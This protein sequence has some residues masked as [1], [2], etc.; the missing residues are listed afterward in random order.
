MA[1][2]LRQRRLSIVICTYDRERLLFETL[3]SIKKLGYL[4]VHDVI[5]VENTDEEFKRKGTIASCRARFPQIRIV[6]SEVAGLSRARNIGVAEAVSEIIAFL[7]DDAIPESGWAEGI[8]SCCRDDNV[9]YGGGPI[10][11]RWESRPPAWM[12]EEL[13]SAFTILDLGEHSR[14]L[15]QG[16]FVYGANMFF[17]ASALRSIGGFDESLGRVRNNL[18]GEEDLAVQK[19][20]AKIGSG[21]YA[22]NSRVKHFI[23]TNRANWPWLLK[24]FAWQGF[25]EISQTGRL[26]EYHREAMRVA[27]SNARLRQLFNDLTGEPLSKKDALER[28]GFIRA[29]LGALFHGRPEDLLIDLGPAAPLPLE[30]V[31]ENLVSRQCQNRS[32]TYRQSMVGKCTS[33]FFEFGRSH[34]Y[35]MNA[36]GDIGGSKLINPMF[37]PWDNQAATVKSLQQFQSILPEGTRPFFFTLDWVLHNDQ[38][39]AELSHLAGAGII[40]RIDQ[41]PTAIRNLKRVGQSTV[42]LAYSEKTAKWVEKVSGSECKVIRHPPILFKNVPAKTVRQARDAKL[43]SRTERAIS[44]ALMGEVRSG[45]GFELVIQELA[46][47]LRSETVNKIVLCLVGGASATKALELKQ[48]LDRSHLRFEF[49]IRSRT[50]MDYRGISDARFAK[51]MQKSDI[52]LF[53]YSGTESDSMSGHLVDSVFAGCRVMVSEES[54]MAPLVNRWSIGS[55]F[56]ASKPSDLAAVLEK[57][58]GTTSF[59]RIENSNLDEFASVHSV[60]AINEELV[61]I[62]KR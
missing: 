48:M 9:V 3:E 28:L 24:R 37:S 31:S 16:E 39:V 21:F 44:V 2:Q 51:L 5:V 52:M 26:E 4:G 30:A 8:L 10:D 55:V 45:K 42:L 17:R 43:T 57:E 62:L 33:M 29:M 12:P 14:P 7:D 25:S 27:K 19:Q 36:Y 46:A 38:A 20:L 47:K 15:K 53:P 6:G 58:L 49:D 40:H 50:A 60:Q 54:A 59:S 35:L 34:S 13:Y 23:P 11:P 32:L 22:A 1:A 18:H 56:S 61:A 41:A